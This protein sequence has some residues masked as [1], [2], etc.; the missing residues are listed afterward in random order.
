MKNIDKYVEKKKKRLNSIFSE[1]ADGRKWSMSFCDNF[2]STIV[3]DCQT[4][5]NIKI[6]DEIDTVHYYTDRKRMFK[7]KL[8]EAGVEVEE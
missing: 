7:R 8:K 4:K 2:I 5:V 1:I 3:E 6:F